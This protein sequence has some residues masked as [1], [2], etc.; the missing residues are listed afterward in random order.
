MLIMRS[1]KRQMTQGIEQLNQEKRK[2][3][4]QRKENLQVFG[5]IGSRH[6]QTNW[7]ERKEIKKSI[8]VE[9]ENNSKPSYIAEASSKW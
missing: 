6:H 9:Q 1:G 4:T 2:R 7:N 3:K 8:P 5:N